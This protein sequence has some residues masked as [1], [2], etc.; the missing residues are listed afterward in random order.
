MFSFLSLSP[1]MH[2]EGTRPSLGLSQKLLALLPWGEGGGSATA[3]SLSLSSLSLSVTGCATN[4]LL[5]QSFL[6]AVFFFVCALSSIHLFM[7]SFS[8]PFIFLPPRLPFSPLPPLPFFPSTTPLLDSIFRPV[9]LS[10]RPS[11]QLYAAQLA[12]MQV[13]PGSKQH[14]VSLPPQANLGTHSP[15]T[16]THPQ[17]DKGRSSPQSNK[18]KVREPIRPLMSCV[19]TGARKASGVFCVRS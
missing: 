19:H 14:G 2:L 18:T 8:S 11:Q 7:P 12:A 15:P 17:S 9:Y 3:M 10:V 4:G 5:F 6:A 13:S 1:T 16:N